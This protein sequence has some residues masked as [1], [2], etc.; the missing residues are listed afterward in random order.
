MIDLAFCIDTRNIKAVCCHQPI[1]GIYEEKITTEHI[2]Q[3]K[4]NHWLHDCAGHWGF[5]LL[6]A[7]K[8]HQE[9][10]VDIDKFVWWLF[11]SYRPLN[12]VTWSFEFP[13]PCSSDSIEDLGDSYGSLF[14]ISLKFHSGFH[15]IKVRP[16]DQEKLAFV[17]PD[18]KNKCFVVIP[19]GSTNAPAFYTTMMRIFQDE[20]IIIFQRT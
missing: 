18:G 8:P 12:S 15:Q 13:I 14:F 9:P 5:I 1:Y 11:I 7:A 3:I 4:N 2:S 6:L 10:C 19:F 20:W 17:I 16:C